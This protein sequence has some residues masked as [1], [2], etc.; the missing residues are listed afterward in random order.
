MQI[1]YCGRK[2]GNGLGGDGIIDQAE[3]MCLR[4]GAGVENLI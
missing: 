1:W 4:V 3:I 2:R